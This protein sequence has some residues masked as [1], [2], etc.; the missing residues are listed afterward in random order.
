VGGAFGGTGLRREAG[1]EAA[2]TLRRKNAAIK[3]GLTGNTSSVC[4][5]VSSWE[6]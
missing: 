5:K 1:A 3:R 2:A 6:R 4:H